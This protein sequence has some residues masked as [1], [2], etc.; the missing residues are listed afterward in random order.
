MSVLYGNTY[1]CKMT[2][3]RHTTV[4][5][6]EN[7]A[8]YFKHLLKP[9]RVGVVVKDAEAIRNQALYLFAKYRKRQPDKVVIKTKRR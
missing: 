6:T 8:L 5:K 3:K 2:H 4:A 7:D 1:S 9:F